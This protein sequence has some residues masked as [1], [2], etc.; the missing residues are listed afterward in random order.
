[1]KMRRPDRVQEPKKPCKKQGEE[2]ASDKKGTLFTLRSV[3]RKW[4]CSMCTARTEMKARGKEE[5]K[6]RRGKG[7]FLTEGGEARTSS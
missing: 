2:P 1:L 4:V 3:E 6:K 7:K 5:R